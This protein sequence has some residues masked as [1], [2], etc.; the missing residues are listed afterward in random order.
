[1]SIKLLHTK[2][3]GIQHTPFE[4]FLAV[5][6]GT[7]VV[8]F[9]VMLLK[10]SAI[11]LGGTV[12]LSMMLHHMTGVA[13]GVWFFVVNLP[14]YYLGY[15]RLG[16]KMIMRTMVAVVLLS[17]MTEIHPYFVDIAQPSP[18]YV[19][20]LANILIGIGLLIL[21]RHRTTLGGF[22]LLALDI[23]DRHN[24]PAGKALM[25]M[26]G[27]VL[28]FSL[29]YLNLQTFIL[30]IIGMLILNAILAMNFRKDRYVGS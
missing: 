24:I 18:A 17:A 6:I 21:F 9:G 19:V 12:G 2:P 15:R 16:G 8:G 30:S 26:D 20:I 3:R 29:F 5:L 11:A 25:V 28:L 13:F 14:F 7:F 27:A 22:N 4:D 10:Q 1:M 23:Q